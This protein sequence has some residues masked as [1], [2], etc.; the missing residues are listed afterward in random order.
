MAAD[1]LS[2]MRVESY[3]EPET[4]LF[5]SIEVVERIVFE[6]LNAGSS[7]FAE[8]SLSEQKQNDKKRTNP[9]DILFVFGTKRKEYK[10]G[11]AFM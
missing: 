11:K 7:L 3:D 4:V 9:Y 6:A 2:K 1:S 5:Y 10:K 8:L